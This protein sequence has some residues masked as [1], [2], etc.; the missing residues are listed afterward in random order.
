MTSKASYSL[1][2]ISSLAF[3]GH[4]IS[5]QRIVATNDH[6]ISGQIQVATNSCRY[7]INY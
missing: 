1:Q 3:S 6:I 7:F 2:E 4:I 5:G